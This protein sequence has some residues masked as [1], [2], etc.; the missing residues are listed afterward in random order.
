MPSTRP[1]RADGFTLIELVC[2]CA[3]IGIL[4][5]TA[6]PAVGRQVWQ[7][8]VAAETT[9]LQ[10]LAAAVQA[11]FESADLEGTNLAAL[12][13]TIGAGVDPTAFSSSTDPTFIPATTAAADWF[14]KLGRQLGSQ[15]QVGVA[16]TPALQPQLAEI[17]LNRCGN[18]RLLLL[19][20][21]NEAAQQRFLLVSLVAP[22]EQLSL[23]PWPN[24][25][26]PQD[27][28]N[29][30]LFNDL[31]NTSWT[32]A[33]AGLPPTWTA[34]L[35]PAQAQAWLGAGPGG[36]R[37]WQ[38]CVQRI[39]CPKYTIT[40]NNTH[41]TDNGYVYYNFQGAV[42]GSSATI[43]AN[44]GAMVIPNVL[45]GRLIQA[46]RGAS[47]ATA[48]LFSQFNLRDNNEITLQD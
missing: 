31:W 44:S 33:A 25:A 8:R 20:P 32:S 17:L 41:P 37:L 27:P 45:C 6:T 38:L 1:R 43:P 40:I 39:V 16:P 10:A 22:A 47:A 14:A 36:R 26:N 23:P 15:P 19:G 5:A 9:A 48:Q 7:A 21:A 12:P 34:A 4:L 24:P 46:Y 3:V 2:V 42:A 29:L 30:A 28:A 13:G 18:A 11:S 35:S